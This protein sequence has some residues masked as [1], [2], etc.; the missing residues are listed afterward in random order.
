MNKKHTATLAVALLAL[1]GC[2]NK[3]VVQPLPE[4]NDANCQVEKIKQ[5]GNEASRQEFA[6]K[7]SRRTSGTARTEHP[8][9]W[10]EFSG[11]NGGK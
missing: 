2:D 3:P 1:A 4:I 5:I 9:N 7:C 10:L 6:G 11:Q 8:K